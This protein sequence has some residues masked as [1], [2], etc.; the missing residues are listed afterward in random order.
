MPSPHFQQVKNI[1]QSNPKKGKYRR[2][3]EWI[4]LPTSA[5]KTP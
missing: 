4:F 3:E 5:G 1:I 2:A